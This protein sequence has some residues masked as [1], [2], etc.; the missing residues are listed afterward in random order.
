MSI[1]PSFGTVDIHCCG[2]KI[3]DTTRNQFDGEKHGSDVTFS[4]MCGFK[5]NPVFKRGD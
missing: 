2:W 3:L 5:S 1:T 4:F